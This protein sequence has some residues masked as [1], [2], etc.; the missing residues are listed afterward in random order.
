VRL[1]STAAEEASAIADMLRRAHLEEGR[2]WS[3][4]AVLVRSA[5]RSLPVLRRTLV[6]A[7]VPVAAAADE[8]PVGRDPAVAPLLLALRC[9]AD[10]GQLDEEAARILLTSPL[11]RMSPP[12]LRRL[13]RA[14]RAADRET[15]STA[16]SGLGL[17]APSARLVRG[18]L[19]VP[20]E[21]LMLDERHEVVAAP[22]RRLAALLRSAGRVLDAGGS[23]EEALWELWNGTPWPRRLR[24]ADRDL[25]AVVALFEELA[26][27]EERRPRSGVGAVLDALEAQEIPSGSRSEGSLAAADAVRLLTAHRS[28]GLEWDLVVVA[29]VQD[30]SWPDVRRRAS[31]LEADRIGPSGVEENAPSASQ[32]LVDERRLFYVAL[33]RARR[34]VV[35]TAVRSPE[36]DGD[37][38]SRFLH[39]LG[40]D[41]PE[42]NAP[43]AALLAL[44]S[45]V[46][47]LRRDVLGGDPAAAAELARLAPV[48]T[49]ANP[50][51]WWGTR[52][53]TGGVRPVRPVGEPVRLSG[54][55]VSGYEQCPLAWFL[56]REVHAD[57]P[58]TSAQGFGLVVHA[59]ARLVATGAV[60]ADVPA[61]LTRLDEVWPALGF[62]AAWLRDR[63]REEARAALTRFLA[64]HAGRPDRELLAAE[65]GFDVAAGEARLR[66]SIDRLERDT[67]GRVHVADLKTGRAAPAN[68]AVAEHAQL[69]VYQLAVRDGGL[70]SLGESPVLGGAELVHL[71][72]GTRAGEPRVQR[73]EPLP[74]PAGTWADD[75]V[76]RVAR[77]IAGVQFPARPNDDCDR[78]A[79]RT[80]CPAQESGGQVVP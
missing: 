58:S 51:T 47:R 57:R 5:R 61:L 22:V 77:G 14:L 33:T 40:V 73:Q 4:L 12:E 74:G 50:D 49:A 65:T 15:R 72:L 68:A 19:A 25:D 13:G 20:E 75:L 45:V 34:R 29:G 35:V 71:R 7:G 6:A 26:R 24:A 17:P 11:G 23:V 16:D 44:P 78:C 27:T 60:P 66:G 9:A 10:P 21:M 28:K 63:E 37:R 53:W 56:E 2:P 52:Q 67:Q 3:S 55:A 31:L 70:T 38:P 30:G 8:I 79:F 41:V 76:L 62:P 48:A 59:L 46:A 54:T 43:A 64:W 32:L 80:S 1:F 18:A 42:E 69:A 39:E 36:D